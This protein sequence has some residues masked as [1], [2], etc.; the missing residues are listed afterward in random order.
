MEIPA[1]LN[2]LK[3]FYPLFSYTRWFQDITFEY[4]FAGLNL[5]Y[6]HQSYINVNS[7]AIG[8]D[9]SYNSAGDIDKILRFT[10]QILPERAGAKHKEFQTSGISGPEKKRARQKN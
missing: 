3:G 9:F 5:K 6:I 7:A 4:L 1:V 2:L 10:V 8:F